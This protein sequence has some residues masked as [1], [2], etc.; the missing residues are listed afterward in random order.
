MKTITTI[1]VKKFI[2]YSD[3]EE[4]LDIRISRKEK[5]RNTYNSIALNKYQSKKLIKKLKEMI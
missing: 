2:R 5:H 4:C 1:D 3:G